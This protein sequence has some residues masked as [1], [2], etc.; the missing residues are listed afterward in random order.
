[1]SAQLETALAAVASPKGRPAIDAAAN[2]LYADV[3]VHAVAAASEEVAVTARPQVA[4]VTSALSTA[5]DAN[6]AERAIAMLCVLDAALR[7][8]IANLAVPQA[9]AHLDAADFGALRDAAASAVGAELATWI[10]ASVARLRAAA[11]PKQHAGAVALMVK[12]WRKQ[13]ALPSAALDQL[14]AEPT[15]PRDAPQPPAEG[16]DVVNADDDDAAVATGA[17][18]PKQQAR[19]P[20]AE[21]IARCAVI[22]EL[23]Q[24]LSSL[25]PDTAAPLWA[26]LPSH[27]LDPMDTDAFSAI[28]AVAEEAVG[29]AKRVREAAAL[30]SAAARAGQR[31]QSALEADVIRA[32]PAP[33]RLQCDVKLPEPSRSGGGSAAVK[34]PKPAPAVHVLPGHVLKR[35]PFP[36]PM[37]WET[38][39]DLARVSGLIAV[40]E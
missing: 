34:L 31:T 24:A 7:A 36:S 18:A 39:K 38:E 35:Q 40:P 30:K 12:A 5:V 4:A 37:Q 11:L 27:R 25:P 22:R 15:A 33:F 2:A 21:V 32:V 8:N 6:D 3:I 10:P 13:R 29:E 28:R 17:A 23:H 1:M 9:A 16:R 26:A 20:K 14:T 19:V